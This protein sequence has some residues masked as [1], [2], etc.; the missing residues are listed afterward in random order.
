MDQVVDNGKSLDKTALLQV[1]VQYGLEPLHASAVIIAKTSMLH[2]PFSYHKELIIQLI[3]YLIVEP[4]R[5][6]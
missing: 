2:E 1:D 4:K 3:F 6:R 5:S